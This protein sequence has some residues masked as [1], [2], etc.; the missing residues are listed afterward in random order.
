MY[1]KTE[2]KQTAVSLNYVEYLFLIRNQMGVQ[3][4]W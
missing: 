3:K 4:I 2:Q 1:G